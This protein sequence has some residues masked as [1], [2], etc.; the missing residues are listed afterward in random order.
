MKKKKMN[1]VMKMTMPVM[2]EELAKLNML[3][4]LK[5]VIDAG[6]V[7]DAKLMEHDSPPLVKIIIWTLEGFQSFGSWS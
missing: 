2:T 3:M 6:V 1:T 5:M 4:M 7:I